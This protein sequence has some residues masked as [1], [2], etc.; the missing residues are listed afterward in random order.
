M[1]ATGMTQLT[2]PFFQFIWLA[3][4]PGMNLS[5]LFS[6]RSLTSLG[7]PVTNTVLRSIEA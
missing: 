3:S 1:I 7:N 2:C 5:M 4:Y 6:S